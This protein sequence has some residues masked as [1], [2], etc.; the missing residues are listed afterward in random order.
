MMH[1]KSFIVNNNFLMHHPNI[2]MR[3]SV[4]VKPRYVRGMRTFVLIIV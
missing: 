1:E 3:G 4:C 2:L